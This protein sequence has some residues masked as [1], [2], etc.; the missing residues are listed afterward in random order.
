MNFAVEARSVKNRKFVEAIMPSMIR[1][2]GLQN[3]KKTVLV[4]VAR[5]CEGQGMTVPIDGLD[6]YVVIVQPGRLADMGVT[7]A[8]E[9]VHVQQ[10]SKGYLKTS[11]NGSALWC[12]KKFGKKTKY[13]EQPWEVNAF[14]K[15]EIIFRK[16]IEE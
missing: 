6:S 8:H 11:K 1:Q 15:Q 3:S 14:S 16:A 9:M 13:L 12:G 2:L 7:L 5:E 4:R 10:M